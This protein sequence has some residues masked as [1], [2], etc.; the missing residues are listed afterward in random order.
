MCVD[1]H[2][3]PK[4][5]VDD[6]Q[7]WL[8][9]VREFYRK[10]FV[11]QVSPVLLQKPADN[12]YYI[13]IELF[14]QKYVVLLDSGCTNTVIG[15]EG[16][17]F[18]RDSGVHINSSPFTSVCL[19]DGALRQVTGLVDLPIFVDS[20]CFVVSALV[21][22]SLTH[23]VIIGSD[24]IKQ[25][26]PLIDFRTK[27]WQIQNFPPE[28]CTCSDSPVLLS[29]KPP[30]LGVIESLPTEQAAV[31]NA[32]VESFD[33]VSSDNRLG[34]TNKISLTI[35]TGDSK[36]FKKRPFLM[37]PYMQKILNEELDEMLSLGVV[38]PSTS[39][40]SSPV[41]LVKKKTGEYRFC[42]DGRPLNEVTKH[43][44]YPLP[45]VD[46]ILNMLRDAK[47]I[48]SV[49]LRKS[50][51]QIPLDPASREKTAFS[52]VGRGQFQ[53]VTMPFGL[54]NAAQ[55]QQ[56]L[57][58]AIFGPKYEPN[59]FCYLDD[60]IICSSTFEEHVQ[61][62]G[63]VR[64]KLAEANLTV[65]LKKCEFFKTSLKFLGFVVG[66]NSLC[67]DPD[68]IS[69]MVNYPRPTTSTEV[70]R[71]VGLC[72]WY[73]RF[74]K[75]F[76]TLL[77]PINDLLKGKKKKEAISWTPAAEASF[78]KIKQA[79]VSAPILSQPDFSQ[80]FSIQC[81]ASDTGLGGV[82]TQ[83]LDGSEKVIAYASRSLSR[84]E[85]NYSVT[86]RECLAVIFSIEKFRPYV[87]GT[88]FQV[89]TD[90]YSLL[91]LSNLKNPTGKLARWSMRLRQHNFDLVHRK[92]A[93]NVV[94]DALSRMFPEQ[95]V[96]ISFLEV[97]T[98][99]I[100]PWFNDLREKITRSPEKFPQ[101]KVENDL[102]YKF[103]PSDIPFATNSVEWKILVPKP[104]RLDVIKSC[105]DPPTAAHFGFFKT[106]HRVQEH[107]YW[108]KMRRDILRYVRSCHT[109]G[110]QKIS[111]EAR[112][113]FMGKEKEVKFPWQVI[114]L[115][116]I[117]PFPRSKRGF[118]W[119]LV[120]GDWFTK[121]TVVHPLR[122]AK[123]KNITD[124]LENHI[125][126]VYGV[127]Q[128][129]I[130][131]NAPNLSGRE[132]RSLCDKYQV[133]KIWFNAVYSAQCNF[134][135]RS[136]KT[137]GT[138][139]RCYVKEHVDW[140]LELPKL[141]QAINTA[142]HEVTK[143]TPAFLNFG[144]H[145]PLSGNYYN[146]ARD[147]GQ[148]LEIMPGDR[149][150]YA[151]NISGLRGVFTDVRESL[152][153]AYLR[154][155]HTYNLRK[156]AVSFTVGDKVWRRN[157]VLSSAANK[158]MAKLAPK[159]ILCTVRKKLS[160]LVYV[161]TNPDGTNAGNWHVKDLKPYRAFEDDASDSSSSLEE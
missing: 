35:D 66:G 91:W 84:T 28:K 5:Q 138:A 117:G 157:K 134:V 37:S 130:C 152:H 62:L 159:Y 122:H 90:H 8:V 93:N 100:D 154:N 58:D 68:K 96:E 141:Q 101:W 128:F 108:P 132:L 123:A 72:S 118:T 30:S 2:P 36:P 155:S 10:P 4:F 125:F 1:R 65:N 156:R 60:I 80:P 23:S 79:L 131:D 149:D 17:K 34:R 109:C 119:L 85:R 9:T 39:P 99:R 67:T 115:D 124:F 105:H 92:G 146:T 3:S 48:S 52:V 40:W 113:G 20:Y 49:D 32:V 41:L 88:K 133:Q 73:R 56:R 121:Y 59:I 83:V 153:K 110:A 16:V 19:A 15:L 44:G 148:D 98:D 147:E 82:L 142:R 13:E 14:S 114:A 69:A 77:S 54:C 137:I 81:D 57:V 160:P 144:R 6:W 97:D 95:K 89:I 22:P 21:V 126:L 76:S 158:F 103:I 145:V 151:S 112:I 70:K 140:D 25:A 75:D 87:E 12:R 107:Y 63:E 18:L 139:I 11:P 116:L 45:H 94:P 143:F 51:W 43:D 33:K 111:N 55:T 127:P 38:E 29:Y 61:L 120:V 86:E 161:L 24:F 50:F 129:V 31:A 53:F 135:E 64:D 102:V 74:I 26:E 27:T 47:Y 104:Q 7:K 150:A 46:R 71:F 106:L 78:H 136:N 42:F